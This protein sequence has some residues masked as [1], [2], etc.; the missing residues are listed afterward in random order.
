MH[1]GL[2]LLPVLPEISGGWTYVRSVL[3]ALA[4]G[5]AEGSAG[6]RFTAFVSEASEAVVPRHPR[7]ARVR[8]PVSA[9][10]RPLRV[11]AENLLLPVLAARHGVE[12]MHHFGA[13][14]PLTERRPNVVTIYDL[15]VFESPHLAGPFK[16]R[17]LHSMLRRAALRSDVVAAISNATARDLRAS[18]GVSDER[19]VVVPSALAAHFTPPDEAALR[20]FRTRYA[21]PP[22]FWLVVAEP[23]PHKNLERLFRAYAAYRAGTPDPWP[24]LL[25]SR[26]TPE[27]QGWL[28]DAGVAG[29]V[30]LLP[31]LADEEMPLLYGAAGAMISPSLFEGVGLPLLEAMAWGCPALASDIPTTHEFA[32][33]AARIFDPT[34]EAEITCAL[35]EVGA[36]ETLRQRY[37]A[38][39][40]ARA[41]EMSS[42]VVAELSLEA[43]R[44]AYA[45]H[46]GGAPPPPGES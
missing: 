37:R 28:R 3:D 34:R 12:V 39:G 43:Y 31:R 22:R 25:R 35:A 5:G 44:R 14:L 16:R 38:A 7:F 8:V 20:D 6:L 26:S 33:D 41:A 30:T 21:L 24:L 4:H 40:L 15:L 42:R 46:R 2:N 32:G 19:L 1:V 36:S 23:Y 10:R 45:R 13:V 11:L 27:L 29:E 17:Y 9:R 18:F